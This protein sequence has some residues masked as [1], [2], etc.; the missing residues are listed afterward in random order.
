MSIQGTGGEERE[1]RPAFPGAPDLDARL[2]RPELAAALTKAGFKMSPATLATKASR[3]GGPPM[4]KW[5]KSRV[6][7][8]WGSSLK[9]ARD[10]LGDPVH[11][12]S[13][14]ARNG[15]SARSISDLTDYKHQ[16]TKPLP[17]TATSGAGRP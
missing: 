14:L 9:W 1:E 2:S 7:Y 4:Q 8:T 13:E 15:V 12:T 11:S 5:G 16:E 10:L 17:L 3:G 6:T